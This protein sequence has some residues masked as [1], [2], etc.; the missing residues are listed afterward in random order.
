LKDYDKNSLDSIINATKS[1]D[2]KSFDSKYGTNLEA[3][4]LSTISSGGKL[5]TDALF[6]G[7]SPSE[8]AKL[9]NFSGEK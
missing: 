6:A 3:G 4:I 7:I 9:E 5:D 1:I 2:T 8:I